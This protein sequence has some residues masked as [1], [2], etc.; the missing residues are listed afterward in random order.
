MNDTALFGTGNGLHVRTRSGHS[1]CA[2]DRML[3]QSTGARLA[4]IE[5]VPLS[6]LRLSPI[7]EQFNLCD[8]RRILAGEEHHDPTELIGFTDTPQ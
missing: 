7:S 1:D 5:V 3:E 2:N 6:D 8:E 4:R